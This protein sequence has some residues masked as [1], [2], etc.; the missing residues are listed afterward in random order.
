MPSRLSG[1]GIDALESHGGSARSRFH[2]SINTR[3]LERVRPQ[4][5]GGGESVPIRGSLPGAN[6]SAHSRLNEIGRSP[7]VALCGV[8]EP[9]GQLAG[10]AQT[11]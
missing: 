2:P 6:A 8:P 11:N 9:C 1:E 3:S 5:A 4:E 10:S 7:E